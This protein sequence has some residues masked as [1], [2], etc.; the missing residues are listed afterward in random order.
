LTAPEPHVLNAHHKPCCT[1]ACRPDGKV[2]ATGGDDGAIKFWD[3]QTNALLAEIPGA[4]KGPINRVA[5]SR[6]GRRLA[7]AG[8]DRTVVVWNVADGNS[9]G[10]VLDHPHPVTGVAFAAD[11]TLVTWGEYGMLLVWDATSGAQLAA[12]TGHEGAVLAVVVGPDNRTLASAGEDNVIRI[13]D[14]GRPNKPILRRTLAAHTDQVLC[15]AFNSDGSRLASGSRDKTLKLWDVRSGHEALSL[16][17]NADWVWSVTFSPDDQFLV[18][19]SG[20]VRV[21]DAS[22]C[23]SAANAVRRQQARAAAAAWHWRE[24]GKCWMS[25]PPH[26]FGLMFHARRSLGTAREP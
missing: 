3:L 12:L 20:G 21:W 19:G 7:S 25:D 10:L 24:V 16:R 9:L 22:P 13:W 15:L 18:T 17:G 1:V 11:S 14:I 23:T 4:H 6:D 5:F 8:G 2:L 26:W